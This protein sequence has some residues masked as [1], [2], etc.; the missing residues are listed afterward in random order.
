MRTKKQDK[1]YRST[2]EYKSRARE[3][4]K[5]WRAA[6]P[7]Y[8]AAQDKKFY[9]KNIESCRR[10]GREQ[11]ANATPEE[12]ERR[13]KLAYVRHLKRK[14]NL[15]PEAKENLYEQQRGLC[16]LCH[17]PLFSCAQSAVDHNHYTNEVRGL[18]HDPCNMQ[19]GIIETLQHDDPETLAEM[20]R[21]LGIAG[22]V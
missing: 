9:E 14:Y 2:P 4:M 19:L 21:V 13:S 15:T 10:K 11:W 18:T 22:K 20:L 7:G 1:A 6:H 5:R 3:Y 8:Q 12:K 17:R 16:Y